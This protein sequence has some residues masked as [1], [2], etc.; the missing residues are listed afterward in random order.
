M[1][2]PSNYEG[3]RRFFW[4]CCAADEIRCNAFM[5]RS[6]C[7]CRAIYHSGPAQL[8]MTWPA[9][10]PQTRRALQILSKVKMMVLRHLEKWGHDT[11]LL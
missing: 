5:S 6:I 9:A 4:D 11:F 7:V 10:D 1:H 2:L 3:R 8:K